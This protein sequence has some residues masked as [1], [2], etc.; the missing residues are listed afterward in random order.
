MIKK[1]HIVLIVVGLGFFLIP[2]LTY[3]CELN[4]KKSCCSKEISS[5]ENEKMDCCK[6]N[7]HPKDKEKEHNGGCKGKCGHSNCTTSS[8]HFIAAFF[9]IKVN[10][11]NFAFSEK[12]SNY[13]NSETNISS[14]F[15]SIW[16]I[17]KIS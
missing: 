1:L 11:C 8:I 9:G 13:F 14:G 3:S 17:P 6:K 15:S 4:S 2:S 10:N 16:L 7:N 5:S 12:E